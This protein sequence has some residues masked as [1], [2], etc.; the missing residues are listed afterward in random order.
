MADSSRPS[1]NSQSTG[2]RH[3]QNEQPS[4]TPPS[5]VFHHHHSDSCINCG[6]PTAYPAPP[7]PDCNLNY[8]PIR[9]PA[10]NLPKNP[11]NTKEVIMRTPVPHRQEVVPL[12]PPYEFQVPT[13]RI[14]NQSDIE[15]FHSSP[16]CAS[17]LGFV[18]SLSESIKSHKLSDPCHVSPAVSTILQ[19]IE[20]LISFVDEIPPV[21]Q[22]GR[23]G[24]V[25]YRIWH[26]RMSSDAESFMQM[27]LPSNLL[28]ATVELVP[29]F[30]DSFGNSS[31][32][33]Y[34]NYIVIY[35]YIFPMFVFVGFYYLF[36]CF[37]I[38]A[39]DEMI[40]L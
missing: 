30:T 28:D 25:A 3:E 23:Y 34:G 39:I 21:P 4:E 10:V 24:N 22:P 15:R 17:F 8:I 40:I 11:T 16:T 5:V 33:D 6:G 35:I 18:V 12:T 14:S 29:Y 37:C 13:K 9:F 36:I 27:I 20:K 26:E 1:S 19:V 31:R 38:G 2:K 7:P 32:I